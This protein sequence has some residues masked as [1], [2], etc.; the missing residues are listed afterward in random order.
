MARLVSTTYGDALFELAKEQNKLDDLAK[1]VKDV[2][3]VL[4]QNPDFSKLMN[5]PKVGKDEKL[6]VVKEVFDGRLDK[7][8]VGFLRLIVEK[9]RYADIDEIL[10]YFITRVKEEKGIG[11]AYVTSAVKL[12]EIQKK[13]IEEK[14][15]ET[16]KYKEMEMNFA[17][18]DTLIGGLVIRIG[19][20]VVDSSIKS[21]LNE[22]TKQLMKIQLA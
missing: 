3:K 21:K 20:K 4:A 13:L 8:L 11:I 12:S 9:D 2:Q 18:D 7:E 5:H 6:E 16:T 17:Q 19:D 1:E 15:I 22:L 14:L 10:A